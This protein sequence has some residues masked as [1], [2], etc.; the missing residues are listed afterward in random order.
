[1]EV[2]DPTHP[3]FGRRFPVLSISSP[4][5]AS[6]YVDVAYREYMTLRIPKHAT[7]LVPVWST[8]QTKLT[9]AAVK[10]L[11][12]VAEEGKVLCQHNLKTSGSE[13][14]NPLNT[15]SLTNCQTS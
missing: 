6:G 15:K 14:P 4:P 7:N 13:Y 1:V 3:L 9:V 12:C 5:N 11:I 10:Q 2:T 8:L